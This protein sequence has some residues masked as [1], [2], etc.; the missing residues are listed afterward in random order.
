MSGEPSLEDVRYALNVAGLSPKSHAYADSRGNIIV[1]VQVPLTI[2]D[3]TRITYECGRDIQRDLACLINMVAWEEDYFTENWQLTLFGNKL[4]IMIGANVF[5]PKRH[6][7]HSDNH[8][9]L[10]NQ[11]N[12]GGDGGGAEYIYAKCISGG[13]F[14]LL[15]IARVFSLMPDTALA[16]LLRHGPGHEIIRVNSQEVY[17]YLLPHLSRALP[18]GDLRWRSF[19]LKDVDGWVSRPIPQVG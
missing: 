14:S 4:T 13:S 18:W 15:S 2:D 11:R 10:I 17:E 8:Y 16:E 19:P 1:K 12:D 6:N 3:G 9:P 5:L 7:I